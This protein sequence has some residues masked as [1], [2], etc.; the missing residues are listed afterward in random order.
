MLRR[1]GRILYAIYSPFFGLQFLINTAILSAAALITTL[2]VSGDA[3]HHVGWLWSRLN[4]FMTG[5]RVSVRGLEHIERGRP[6]VLMAYHQSQYD[7]FEVYGWVPIQFRWVIK[8]T[9][10]KVP[11]L[12]YTLEKMGHIY[13]DRGNSDRAAV[14]LANAAARI[15]AGTSVFFFPEGTRSPDGRLGEFKSGGFRVAQ[16]AGVPILPVT[17]NG[18]RKIWRRGSWQLLPG[19][20]EVIVHAPIPIPPGEER[21]VRQQLIQQVRAAI[22]SDLRVD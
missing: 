19:K 6:Y 22:E 21:E 11:L 9:M 2:F 14:S 5:A 10:R 3:G 16:A 12:G 18:G 15:R 4:I 1:I 7:I 13:V 20:L 17:L 8:H